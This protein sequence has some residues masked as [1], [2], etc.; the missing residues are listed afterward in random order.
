MQE[1]QDLALVLAEASMDSH[2]TVNGYSALLINA[3]EHGNLGI[4]YA[5][6]SQLLQEGRWA[7]E[8]ESRLHHPSY[9]DRKVNVVLEKT[10]TSTAVTITDQGRGFNW[11]NYLDFKPERAFD[12]HGRGIAISRAVSFDSIGYLGNGNTVVTTVNMSSSA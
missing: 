2:R 9:S 4:G 10:V 12:L 7:D 5:D 6:K 1:A 11:H 8:I 3:V